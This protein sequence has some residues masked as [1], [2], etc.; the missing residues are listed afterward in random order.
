M[1]E[2]IVQY[3]AQP[4]KVGCDEKCNK[5]WGWANRPSEENED[6]EVIYWFSDSDLGDAP[7][8]PGTYE[9]RD[10]KPLSPKEFPNRWCVRQCERCTRS[11]FG[12]SDKPLVYDDWN[13]PVYNKLDISMP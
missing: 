6:G 4:M 9:G 2:K 10:A 3:F 13:K 8:N 11:K 12:E 1:N 7:V 5:A